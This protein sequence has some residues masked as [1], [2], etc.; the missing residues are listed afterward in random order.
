MM[1]LEVGTK[2]D[3]PVP[4][5]SISI[6]NLDPQRFDTLRYQYKN[7]W[8]TKDVG[9]GIGKAFLNVRKLTF[10]CK[11]LTPHRPAMKLCPPPQG[12]FVEGSPFLLLHYVG[13]WES[14]SF[15]TN[16]ARKGSGREEFWRGRTKLSYIHEPITATWLE[17]FIQNV[18][19]KRASRLLRHAG[20]PRGYNGS[21][22]HYDALIV[23]E[24]N[25]A[26]T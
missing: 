15:R 12:K 4:S 17:G 20:L 8:G 3:P 7:R 14:F 1:K 24:A 26:M 16:D 11:V 21:V 18:G 5:K 6:P 13:S 25:A 9:N 19:E 2:E 23:T 10:P 22:S